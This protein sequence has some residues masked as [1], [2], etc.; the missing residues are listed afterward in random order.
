MDSAGKAEVSR[1]RSASSFA[2]AG[3][4]TE[5]SFRAGARFTVFAVLAEVLGS[6][7]SF[8]TGLDGDFVFRDG[9]ELPLSRISRDFDESTEADF[10]SRRRFGFC[11]RHRLFG[12]R[13]TK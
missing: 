1:G 4:R 13:S 12:S 2:A 10:L 5:D 6:R 3:F 11:G 9:M 8:A 7:G